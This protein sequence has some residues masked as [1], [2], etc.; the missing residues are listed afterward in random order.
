MV[1]AELSVVPIGEGTSVSR[2]IRVAISVLKKKGIKYEVGGM[3]TVMEAEDLDTLFSAIKEAHEA[4]LELGAKRVI[5]TIKID[6]RR[7][8]LQTI[9]SKKR[10]V[11]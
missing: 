8:K 10:A 5:T 7:D 11:E 9:E 4:V 6:D 2:H 3:S 1:I